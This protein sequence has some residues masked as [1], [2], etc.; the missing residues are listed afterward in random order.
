MSNVTTAEPTIR[1]DFGNI[2]F[3]FSIPLDDDNRINPHSLRFGRNRF[4]DPVILGELLGGDR[5]TIYLDGDGNPTV[6]EG[7][8]ETIFEDERSFFK[9]DGSDREDGDKPYTNLALRD[10]AEWIKAQTVPD[11]T[12]LP[13][14][15]SNFRYL[16]E[17]PIGRKKRDVVVEF[18]INGWDNEVVLLTDDYQ[19]VCGEDKANMLVFI[20]DLDPEE[21]DRY[22]AVYREIADRVRDHIQ[23]NPYHRADTM[24]THYMEY[25]TRYARGD[26]S[27][28][29]RYDVPVVTY[30]SIPK[31]DEE[32]K[33][34]GIP[35]RLVVNRKDT[36]WEGCIYASEDLWS[37]CSQEATRLNG[38]FGDYL[39]HEHFLKKVWTVF[40][41]VDGVDFD[42]IS[43]DFE[44]VATNDDKLRELIS[45][46]NA[47][48]DRGE[49]SD[50]TIAQMLK[51]ALRPDA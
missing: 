31:T 38:G 5:F 9:P 21:Q 19:D 6:I 29:I 18:D 46:A 34:N 48:M 27:N 32:R 13:L 25:G 22:R 20:D 50:M 43:D 40:A 2:D 7:Y 36:F 15:L 8:G 37:K 47:S 24:L 3:D 10:T 26:T 30:K 49:F 39:S 16:E 4:N 51:E 42:F 44:P 1:D 33:A 12:D 45:E 28:L 11:Y 41:F 23:M 35:A 14:E 17:H